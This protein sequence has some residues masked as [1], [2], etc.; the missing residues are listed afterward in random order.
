MWF[1]TTTEITMGSCRFWSVPLK[2]RSENEITSFGIYRGNGGVVFTT[3]IAWRCL[4][5]AKLVFP[6]PMNTPAMQ[7]ITPRIFCG[8]WFRGSSSWLVF[9]VRLPWLWLL[10]CLFPA[11]LSWLRLFLLLAMYLS[12]S[13][14]LTNHSI[15]SFRMVQSSM[16]RAYFYGIYTICFYLLQG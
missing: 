12:S 16:V 2:S 8:Y 13:P 1:P 9:G 14:C 5:L 4:F 6:P 15:W 3:T 7:F 11:S 10:H